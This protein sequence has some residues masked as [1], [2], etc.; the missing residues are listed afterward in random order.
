MRPK[1]LSALWTAFEREWDR[2]DP[3][4]SAKEEERW[5]VRISDIEREI[6]AAPAGCSADIVAKLRLLRLRVAQNREPISGESGDA[7]ILSTAIDWLL[8]QNGDRQ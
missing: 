1:S 5:N 6:E 7:K 4:W 3:E 2:Y 8:Q